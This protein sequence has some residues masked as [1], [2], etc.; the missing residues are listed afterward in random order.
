MSIRVQVWRSFYQDSMVLMRLAKDLQERPG[1]YRSAALMGTPANHQ[2][3]ASAGLSHSDLVE[4]SPVDL[5]LAVEAETDV[6]AEAVLASAK[7]FF[8]RRRRERESTGRVLPRTLESALR[9]RPD[10][11]LALVSVPGAYATFEAMTAL[12]R[13]L[14]VFLFS[15]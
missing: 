3:L 10:A 13:G 1:V 15:D 11:N 5:M 7:E 9:L 4:A 2:L 8:D 12:R 6:A 14:H